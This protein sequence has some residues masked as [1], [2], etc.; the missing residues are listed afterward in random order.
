MTTRLRGRRA[1]SRRCPLREV[2]P[3]LIGSAPMDAGRALGVVE[4]AA[5]QALAAAVAAKR[6]ELELAHGVG[7]RAVDS[8]RARRAHYRVALGAS[9]RGVAVVRAAVQ[10]AAAAGRVSADEAVRRRGQR[11]R[12]DDVSVRRQRSRIARVDAARPRA[13]RGDARG[14]VQLAFGHGEAPRRHPTPSSARPPGPAS[15][16]SHN[17]AASDAKDAGVGGDRVDGL[18][19]REDLVEARP[20]AS[21]GARALPRTCTARAREHLSSE[22][23]LPAP[24]SR[25]GPI[26]E[27]QAAR[28]DEGRQGGDV[29][30]AGLPQGRAAVDLGRRRRNARRRRKGSPRNS[31]GSSRRRRSVTGSSSGR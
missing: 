20:R 13:R 1:S 14:P 11:G 21:A 27:A 19:R 18:G 31:R 28:G 24:D 12:G 29:L 23:N 6:L 9:G 30:G 7:Q 22:R 10:V 8:P 25:A 16:E 4:M 2:F 26:R 5:E 3:A 17:S 15:Q